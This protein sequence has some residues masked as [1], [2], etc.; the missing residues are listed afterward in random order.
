L[1]YDLESAKDVSGMEYQDEIE[2][3]YANPDRNRFIRNLALSLKG[4]TLLMFN[5]VEKHG[6]ILFAD[7]QAKA[8][9]RAIFYVS[10]ETETDIREEI[11]A[12]IEK[13]ENAIICASTVFS[14][15]TNMKKLHNMIF[16]APSKSRIRVLQ[17]IGRTLRKS[18]DKD[19]A[20]LYDIVDDLRYSGKPN[21]TLTHAWERLK[22][23]QSEQFPVKTY[24][25]ALNKGLPLDGN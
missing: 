9:D 16:T 24:T 23:Y 10:G 11:R 14:A 2:W 21:Y 13:E 17:S 5:Y 25:I 1:Q 7:L 20:T 4:N 12:I 19:E 6:K 8:P 3:L 18:V 15:G 22:I